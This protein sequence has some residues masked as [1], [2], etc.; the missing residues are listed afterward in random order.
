LRITEDNVLN[1]S[2]EPATP[3]TE[4]MLTAPVPAVYNKN[5]PIKN[6]VPDLEWFDGDRTKFEDW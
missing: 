5:I 2:T 4:E 3:K 6:I 1:Q